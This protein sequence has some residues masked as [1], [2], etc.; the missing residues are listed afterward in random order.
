MSPYFK[1]CGDAGCLEIRLRIAGG[2]WKLHIRISGSPW[3]MHLLF[4]TI[5][6]IGWD[7]VRVKHLDKLSM[8]GHHRWDVDTPIK[9]PK[10]GDFYVYV[11]AEAYGTH[12]HSKGLGYVDPVVG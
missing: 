5:Y 2:G 8:G 12:H 6:V 11:F 7:G 1:N 9:T 10:N 3:R 4:L